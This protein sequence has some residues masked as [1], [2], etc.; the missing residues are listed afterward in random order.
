MCWIL[1]YRLG[2][3]FLSSVLGREQRGVRVGQEKSIA[4]TLCLATAL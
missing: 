3:E 4:P 1:S 2:G